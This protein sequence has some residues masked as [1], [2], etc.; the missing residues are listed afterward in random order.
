MARRLGKPYAAW[1]DC[2]IDLVAEIFSQLVCDL[3]REIHTGVVHGENDALNLKPFIQPLFAHLDTGH[4][5]RNT[6]ERTASG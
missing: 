1:D 3:R 5:I 2:V 4:Q 6:L